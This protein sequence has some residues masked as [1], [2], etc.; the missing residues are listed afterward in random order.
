MR[1]EISIIVPV[2][3]GEKYISSFMKTITNQTIYKKLF[4]IFVNDGSKDK[5]Y[6]ELELYAQKF[7]KQ[8]KILSKENG[9]VSSA[10]NRGLD[11][12]ETPFF[13][14]A[15]I[16]DL[17]DPF[18]FERLLQVIK[19]TQSDMVCSGMKKITEKQAEELEL[20]QQS[21]EI[22]Q[23]GYTVTNSESAI[24]IMLRIPE[25]NGTPSKI[26]RTDKLGAIRFDEKLDIAEDKLYVFQCMQRSEKIV[27]SE[28]KLYYYIQHP[29]SAMSYAN[30]RKKMGQDVVLNI[31]DEQI[32]V[33]YPSIYPLCAAIRASIHAGSYIKVYTN[34]KNFR[35]KCEIYR[36]SV[37]ACPIKYVFSELPMKS[38]LKVMIVRYIP[39]ILYGKRLKNHR[40]LL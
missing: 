12:V 10:R 34:D 25:Q 15:D 30:A 32:K 4:L 8:I 26:Y 37:I 5:T 16:D 3:N 19:E 13:A 6:T 9:G 23:T 1:E 22:G 29:I 2:Y 36:K 11:L 28:E 21:E 18:L 14:F 38:I 35:K 17:M 24:Q 39:W 20:I 7:P 40:N 33:N 27:F 31:I